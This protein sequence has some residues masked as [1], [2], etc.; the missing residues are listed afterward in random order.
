MGLR[1]QL[2]L[3]RDA[4]HGTHG[5]HRE[6][7]DLNPRFHVFCAF[8]GWLTMGRPGVI[9]VEVD[10]RG[11]E[12]ALVKISGHAVIVFETEITV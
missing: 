3:E 5:L 8:R 11:G 4:N 6:E 2:L 12:P 1:E 10:I 9:R 7:T